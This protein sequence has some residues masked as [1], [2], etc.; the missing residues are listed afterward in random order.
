[1]IELVP[2][3]FARGFLF[4]EAPKWREGLL[5]VSDVFDHKFYALAADGQRERAIDVPTRPSGLGFLSDGTL[6]IASA[7]D[8]RLLRLD[9]DAL[10]E[11][12]DLSSHAAG[13]VN[14][15]AIDARDRIYVG[16]FGYDFV[17]GEDRRTTSLHRVD[18]DGTITTLADGL[19]FPNGSAVIDDGRTLIVAETWEARLTA[20]DLSPEGELSNR[21]VFADL[22]ARQPDGIC[23][24][25]EGAI[26]AGIYN[27]GEFVRV[28]DGGTVTHRVPF[29]GSGISCT[30]G[31][32]DGRTLFMTAF[33]GNDADMEA[34]K[35]NSAVFTVGSDVPGPR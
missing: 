20:F 4:L 16:N 32:A 22:G 31:G 9:G 21:R 28:L 34:G 10:N 14:D 23:A 7:K 13:W 24:D 30:L 19:D 12:A 25:A 27:T 2:T 1:M 17:A 6:I 3:P 26:W 33:I 15:F 18:P 35:R 29:N 5:W 8:R 11:Y